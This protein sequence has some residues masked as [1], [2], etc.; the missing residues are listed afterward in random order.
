[1]RKDLRKKADDLRQDKVT[2]TDEAELLLNNISVAVDT[3]TENLKKFVECINELNNNNPS[4]YNEF[5][6]MVKLPDE[7]DIEKM[8]KLKNDIDES[9]KMLSDEKFV[10]N[11]N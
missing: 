2:N 6:M 10:N 5:K 11:L 8:V 9:I 3:V 7:Q 4:V 1:M